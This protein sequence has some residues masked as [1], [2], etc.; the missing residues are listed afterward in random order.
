[1]S[2]NYHLKIQGELMADSGKAG[3]SMQQAMQVR[4]DNLGLVMNHSYFIN[5]PQRFEQ[6]EHL[7]ELQRSMGRSD[8]IR[9][10]TALEK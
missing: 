10:M 2:F 5:N 3:F 6:L 4:L 1:M 9:K 7:L 8:E